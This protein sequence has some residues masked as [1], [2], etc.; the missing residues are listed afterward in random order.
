MYLV[1]HCH[2]LSKLFPC[3]SQVQKPWQNWYLIWSLYSQ[4]FCVSQC[5]F[6]WLVLFFKKKKKLKHKCFSV[7]FKSVDRRCIYALSVEINP[8]SSIPEVCVQLGAG[9]LFSLLERCGCLW[10]WAA[11]PNRETRV[12]MGT[13]SMIGKDRRKGHQISLGLFFGC[14]FFFPT[15]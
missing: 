11:E 15:N 4:V 13:K 12:E 8:G 1:A 10:S 9:A 7:Y 6:S 2:F 5:Y 3:F 14:W